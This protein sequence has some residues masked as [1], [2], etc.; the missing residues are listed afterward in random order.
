VQAESKGCLIAGL[1]V[2]LLPVSGFW[3]RDG[4]EE[5][6][7]QKCLNDTGERRFVKKL[8]TAASEE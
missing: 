2:L 3:R 8:V 1:F 6:G 4:H 5:A 7:V